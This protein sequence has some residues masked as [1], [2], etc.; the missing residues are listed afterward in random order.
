MDGTIVK[1]KAEEWADKLI[2]E[3]YKHDAPYITT[4]D[5]WYDHKDS[6]IAGYD[7]GHADANEWIKVKDELPNYEENGKRKSK[8]VLAIGNKT[9]HIAIYYPERFFQ[10]DADDWND[11][12]DFDYIEIDNELGAAWL[13]PGW[14]EKYEHGGDSY[15][16]PLYGITHWQLF[17]ELPTEKSEWIKEK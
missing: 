14:Y 11:W 6:F 7:A 13:K 15:F 9:K 8:W 2:P 17:D 10:F 5:R 3:P 16:N 12:D 1:Q 4:E